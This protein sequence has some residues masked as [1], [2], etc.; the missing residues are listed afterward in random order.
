[1]K[2]TIQPLLAAL[3][4]GACAL[5]ATPLSITVSPTTI[6]NNYVGTI[7]LSISNLSSAGVTVRVDRF[8]DVNSNGIVDAS[9][10]AGQSF[11]ITDGRELLIGGVRNSN[12][13]GDDDGLANQSIVTHVP[14]PSVDLTL[15]HISGQYI[16]RVA[17]L[18]NGQTATAIMGIAQQVLPQG[19][20]G[21]VFT[22]G[23]PP[24]ANTAVVVSQQNGNDGWGTV[25]DSSGNFT[26]YAPPGD[27]QLL[28]VSS[29][30]V[31]NP[32]VF[33]INS[34]SFASFDLTNS[35]TDGTTI[36]GN[37]TD[38]S[39]EVGLPGISIEAQTDSGQFTF[40]TTGTNG[41]YNLL[42]NSNNWTLKL[43]GD[44][45]A[46]IGYCR[47]PTNKISVNASS[48]SVSNVNFQMIKGNALVYGSVTTSQSNPIVSVQMDSSD[49]NNNVFDGKGITDA[50][51][52]YSVAVVAGGDEVGPDNSSIAGFISPQND[53]FTVNSGQAIQENFV[54]QPVF[55]Y[56][57]GIVED[58][59][60]SPL[61]NIQL[62]ADPTNDPTGSLNE[63]FQ[64]APD[65]TFSVGVGPGAWNLF[66]ECNTADSDNLISE[67]LTI[68]V[69]NGANVS[70]IVL[71]AQ[72]ST[73]TIFG[74]VTDS[75]SNALS[76]VNMFA[77]AN[78]GGTNYVSGCANTDGNGNYSLPVFPA[79]W[80]VGGN[81]PG[82]MNENAI[83]TGTSSVML[84][85]VVSSQP[86]PPSLGQP[87][88]SGGQ[89]QFQV[90][91]NNFQGYAIEAT[92]N[93]TGGWQPIY[94]NYGSFSFTNAISTNRWR[95]YR[96]VAVP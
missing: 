94:T 13:P 22:G 45:G 5:H 90:M 40:L 25:S 10:W 35:A 87:V 12:V 89:V 56:I 29:G 38:S 75:S 93:L 69:T 78:V 72:H 24:L 85:F 23:G 67:I 66:V 52:N 82:M 64:S 71:V 77:S 84:N 43:S 27:Y 54:L 58:N 1:M 7:Q 32:G 44:E 11:Y 60:G 16:Y 73:A 46:M 3:L 18:G 76:G 4:L 42:V 15:D 68:N 2:L 55:A 62:I 6:S 20:R 95:F 86:G 31:A 80:T 26:V 63:S 50:N 30:Q 57:S 51:G 41:A 53:F 33:T 65:G 74:K 34:N 92:T 48:G 9:K 81:Y 39:S 91:G 47:G 70:N 96:V 21:Q 36:S 19:V 17:D 88:V 61:G 8:L 59:F 79:Q 14:Y 37:V 49:T 83:V 28:T